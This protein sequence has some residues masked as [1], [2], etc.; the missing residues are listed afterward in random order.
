MSIHQAANV[1]QAISA[2]ARLERPARMTTGLIIFAFVTSHFLSHTFGVRSIDAMHEARRYLIMPWQTF[3]GLSLLYGALVTHALLGLYALHRRR[4]LRI[5]AGEAW[6]LAL[7]L[8]IPLLLIQHAGSIR[9]G[10]SLYQMQFGYDRILYEMW[11]LSPENVMRRQLL[12][13]LVAWIHACI[14]LAASCA[15]GPG[16]VGFPACSRLWQRSCRHLPSSARQ[17]RSR[18]A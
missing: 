15:R 17:R 6:Q 5:P 9:V 12:L 16:T 3:P 11:V 4:H 18:H 7:G 10:T 13:L 2:A 1:H 14:G 8:A